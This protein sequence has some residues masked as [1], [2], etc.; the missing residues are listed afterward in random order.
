LIHNTPTYDGGKMVDSETVEW[1]FF[2]VA[3]ERCQW[4]G[5]RLILENRALP[6]NHLL[7]LPQ[8]DTR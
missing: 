7:G 5:K 4:C 3:N 2:D 1:L 8:E 6:A